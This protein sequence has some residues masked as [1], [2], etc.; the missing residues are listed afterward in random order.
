MTPPLPAQALTVAL[1]CLL[2]SGCDDRPMRDE[3]AVADTRTSWRVGPC[4]RVGCY[5]PFDASHEDCH[6]DRIAT[7][8][9]DCAR[10]WSEKVDCR[11]CDMGAPMWRLEDSLRHP[12]G[13]QPGREPLRR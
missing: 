5:E 11:I 12:A 8:F 3:S 6:S 2:L 10:T 4:I 9:Y 1:L 7:L 13:A